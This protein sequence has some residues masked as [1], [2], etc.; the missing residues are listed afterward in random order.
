[1]I[2]TWEEWKDSVAD[3][4]RQMARNIRFLNSVGT[5]RCHALGLLEDLASI[6]AS[7]SELANWLRG[8]GSLAGNDFRLLADDCV[9]DVVGELYKIADA[10]EYELLAA[11][12][13]AEYRQLQDLADYLNDDGAKRLGDPWWHVEFDKQ[14]SL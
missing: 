12:C 14:A 1:M 7:A 13:K 3:K 10:D 2:I 9:S 4:H 5:M 11:R 6:S 8:K